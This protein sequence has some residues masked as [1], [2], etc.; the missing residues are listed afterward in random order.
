MQS[1]SS[2]QAVSFLKEQD[3]STDI[4][5]AMLLDVAPDVLHLSRLIHERMQDIRHTPSVEHLE[6]IHDPLNPKLYGI[7]FGYTMKSPLIQFKVTSYAILRTTR[8]GIWGQSPYLP[9]TSVCIKTQE[10]GV[11]HMSRADAVDLSLTSYATTEEELRRIG[12]EML[13]LATHRIQGMMSF[14]VRLEQ[15]LLDL[16]TRHLEVKTVQHY[17]QAFEALP[18]RTATQSEY[19]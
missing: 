5:A 11:I 12:Q 10:I 6:G 8:Y 4:R 7:R 18:G 3:S 16:M 2:K 14:V 19:F 15:D 1:I 9:N 17:R 13:R